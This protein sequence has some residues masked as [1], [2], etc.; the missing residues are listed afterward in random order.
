MQLGAFR[1]QASE[2]LAAFYPLG[3]ARAIVQLWLSE[4]LNCSAHQLVLDSSQTLDFSTLKSLECD[5]NSLLA[6]KPLQYVTGYCWFDGLKLK[7]NPDVLIPRPET[8]ELIAWV[9][10]TYAN[11]GPHR[12]LDVCTGSGCIA[13]ALKRRYPVASVWGLDW[14]LSALEV[15]RCNSLCLN[16]PIELIH[17]NL[18]EW[19]QLPQPSPFDCLVSNPPYISP[20]DESDVVS[21]SVLTYEPHEALFAPRGNP[22]AFYEAL[23][24][25]AGKWLNRGAFIFAELNPITAER[26][27]EIWIESGLGNVELRP[28]MQGRI[29]MIRARLS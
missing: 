6:L 22:L 9:A 25:C 12:I 8:E 2:R 28:D 26:V 29:R 1:R 19:V 4:R 18:L 3:E 15:A 20:D 17:G 7:V 24:A 13:I 10:E 21:E 27:A 14:S 11:S 5:L 16:L 23:A